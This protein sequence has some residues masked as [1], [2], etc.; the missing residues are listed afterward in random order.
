MKRAIIASTLLLLT[1]VQSWAG[2]VLFDPP[3]VTIQPGT[4]SV[5]FDTRAVPESLSEFDTVNVIFG[6][7]EGLKMSFLLDAALIGDL[8]APPSDQG[9]Y[10]ALTGGVGS[11]IGVG[12]NRFFPLPLWTSVR[13]GVLTVETSNLAAGER[14]QIIVSAEL[15]SQVFG[16]PFSLLAIGATQEPLRGAVTITVAPE[17]ATILGVVICLIALVRARSFEEIVGFTGT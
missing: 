4:Q 12:G 16:A 8:P 14:R 1:P 15:E 11:D 3:A 9:I 13:L 17:P 6:S 10:S 5:S 2:M 7:L